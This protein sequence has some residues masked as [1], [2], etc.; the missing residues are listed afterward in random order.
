MGERLKDKV[1]IVTGGAAGIGQATSILFASEG[2]KVAVADIDEAAGAET[3]AEINARGGQALFVKA[4]ISREADVSRLCEVV[5]A[6]FQRLDILVNNAATFV[7]KGIDATVE[8]WH[9]SLD[10]NV[11]GTAQMSRYAV[12]KMKMKESGG[13]AIINV[14]SIS[15]FVA[16]PSFVTY[17]A[18]KAAILQMTRNMAMDL[19]PFKIRV[20]CVC[21]GTILTRASQDH[22]AR[23]QI[24]EDDFIAEESV[25]HLLGRVGQPMEVAYPILFLVSD[26]ASFITGTHLMVDGGYTTQ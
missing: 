11:I 7:L 10:V 12:A 4:D 9:H 24:K 14:S 15:A 5:V 8:D 16:Q 17:S 3:V 1:A 18:T 21:P 23:M 6:E 13:G 2:A 26:E 20:N 19:A 25:K 22:M